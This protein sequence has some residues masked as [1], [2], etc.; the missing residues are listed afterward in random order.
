MDNNVARHVVRTV[1]R[2]AS[3]LQA[4][5]GV[6]KAHSKP[7]EYRDYAQ[8][9][10]AAIDGINTNLLNR[11]LSSHPQLE[12]EIQADIDKFGRVL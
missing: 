7:D 4:L 12:R 2:S 8:A 5:L 3:E 10:A 6:L 11:V 9:I 1:F